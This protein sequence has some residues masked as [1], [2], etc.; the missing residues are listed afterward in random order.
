LPGDRDAPESL[1]QH[2]HRHSESD[3][4]NEEH[5]GYDTEL[6]SNHEARKVAALTLRKE[7]AGLLGK[8]ESRSDAGILATAKKAICIPSRRPTTL[9][10]EENND[11]SPLRDT[12]PHGGLALE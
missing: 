2:R 12:F 4:S 11:S 9:E 10:D 6:T 5:A 1:F 3:A 8:T 7:L